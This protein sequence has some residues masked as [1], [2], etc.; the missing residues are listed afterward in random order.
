MAKAKKYWSKE[1]TEK[2]DALDLEGGV[3]TWQDPKKIARSL[4]QSALEST[5]RKA[6]P[7]Q[8]AMSMLNFFVNRAGTNLPKKQRKVLEQ[9][10]NELRKLFLKD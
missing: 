6:A 3:F 10:K 8:S 5:R 9:A 1:V 7:F 4:K 2:S